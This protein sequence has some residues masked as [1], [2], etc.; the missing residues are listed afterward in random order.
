[1]FEFQ[2]FKK[3]QGFYADVHAETIKEAVQKANSICDDAIWTSDQCPDIV[4]IILSPE[5][6]WED[7][8]EEDIASV[9]DLDAGEVDLNDVPKE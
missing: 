2:F 5:T 9:Y 3:G 7:Y 8:T 1:M 4:R 6:V